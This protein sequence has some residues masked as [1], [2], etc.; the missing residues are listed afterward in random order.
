M[1]IQPIGDKI[2]VRREKSE[3]KSAGGILLPE[4]SQQKPQRGTILAV[5]PGKMNSKDGQRSAMQVKVG[6][7]VLF[8]TWAGDEYEDK[9]AGK[10]GDILIMSESDVLVVIE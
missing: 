6:D 4:S 5:G 10:E 7:K 1:N 3:G 8:S 9:Q 2:V